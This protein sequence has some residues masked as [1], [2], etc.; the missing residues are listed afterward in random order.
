MLH[1]A[2]RNRHLWVTSIFLSLILIVPC[3]I[4]AF[5]GPGRPGYA[6]SETCGKCHGEVY[7]TW[8]VTPHANMLRDAK[9]NPAVIR[10]KNFEAVPFEKDDI[11]W[12]IGSHW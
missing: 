8:K 5:G 11:Y 12:V 1:I 2:S 3:L 4:Y 9:E 10:A 7:D 6:G